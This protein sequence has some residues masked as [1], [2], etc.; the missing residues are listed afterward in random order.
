ML[1]DSAFLFKDNEAYSLIF[2][3]KLTFQVFPDIGERHKGV[4]LKKGKQ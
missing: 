3:D 4:K 1:V 2:M